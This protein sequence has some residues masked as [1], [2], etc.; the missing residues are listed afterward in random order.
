MSSSLDTT[1]NGILNNI[2]STSNFSGST[3]VIP[4][5]DEIKKRKQMQNIEKE[6]IMKENNR[7]SIENY[8][9][10]KEDIR[11]IKTSIAWIK[12]IIPVFITM[13]TFFIGFAI[14]TNNDSIKLQFDSLNQKLEMHKEIIQTQIQKEVAQEMLK[15][16]K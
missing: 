12:W 9:Q 2:I 1:D 8:I 13:S 6:D 7:I 3:N 10:I 15:Y 11:E 4:I 5:M 16:K 14:N